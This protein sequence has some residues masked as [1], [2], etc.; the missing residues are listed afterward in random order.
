MGLVDDASQTLAKF[1]SIGKDCDISLTAVIILTGPMQVSLLNQLVFSE[2]K[3]IDQVISEDSLADLSC[4]CV[5]AQG[6]KAT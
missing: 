5:I 2:I 1:C 6:N 4:L 3:S